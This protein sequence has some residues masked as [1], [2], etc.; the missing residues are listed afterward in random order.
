MGYDSRSISQSIDA[1]P[2]WRRKGNG[3]WQCGCAGH[4]AHGMKVHVHVQAGTDAITLAP[5]R[6]DKPT[7]AAAS[8]PSSR[9]IVP[10]HWLSKMGH[11]PSLSASIRAGN[12]SAVRRSAVRCAVG[13]DNPLV[14][15]AGQGLIEGAV[16]VP[17]RQHDRQAH[18]PVHASTQHKTTHAPIAW[19]APSTGP[20][21]VEQ[22]NTR[23]ATRTNGLG[24]DD[25]GAL[26]PRAHDA[27][28]GFV[29]LP[30]HHV[31]HAAQVAPA[32]RELRAAGTGWCNVYTSSWDWGWV[33][34]GTKADKAARTHARTHARIP[35]AR[36]TGPVLYPTRARTLGTCPRCPRTA[37]QNPPAPAPA[38]PAAPLPRRL[39]PLPLLLLLLLLLPPLPQGRRPGTRRHPG[40]APGGAAA[41]SSRPLPLPPPPRRP[42]GWCGRL[43]RL[44]PRPGLPR[45]WAWAWASFVS[46][47][48]PASVTALPARASGGGR[49]RC[50]C[51]C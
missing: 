4:H 28:H 44:P 13:I 33:R 9:R 36:P 8:S 47:P 16:V 23:H 21:N 37:R 38:A 11:A 32:R 5:G 42:C 39:L 2:T 20:P 46:P 25:A 3:C 26:V 1:G 15:R 29:V 19:A 41:R 40:A 10:S 50:C 14:G 6:T 18:Q 30:R 35:P 12:H 43:L 45:P 17:I 49:R 27:G 48:A 31:R 24:V 7:S 22:D 34:Y 51:R